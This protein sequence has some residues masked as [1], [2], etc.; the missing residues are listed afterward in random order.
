MVITGSLEEPDQRSPFPFDCPGSISLTPYALAKHATRM[1]ASLFIAAYKLPL[2][3]LIPFMTYGPRQKPFKIVPYTILTLLAGEQPRLSSGKRLV[4]WI[5]IDDVIDCFMAAG[6]APGIEGK[7]FEVGSS[8]LVSIA[9]MANLIAEL[10][11]GNQKILFGAEPD[12]GHDRVSNIGPAAQYLNW[13]PRTPL[14]QGLEATIDWYR[15]TAAS[16]PR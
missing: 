15:R 5:Y 7:I 3:T 8:E 6:T 4:D 2:V 11:P 9:S 13:R 14:G 10:I 16:G 12:R 1:Y